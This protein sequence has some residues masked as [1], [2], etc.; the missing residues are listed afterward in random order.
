MVGVAHQRS[1]GKI[2]FSFFVFRRPWLIILTCVFCFLHFGDFHCQKRSLFSMLDLTWENIAIIKSS[3]DVLIYCFLSCLYFVI[4]SFPILYKISTR[5]R[6]KMTL[7]LLKCNDLFSV[8]P[9]RNGE[10]LLQFLIVSDSFFKFVIKT[11][12]EKISM[13]NKLIVSSSFFFFWVKRD[14]TKAGK[15]RCGQAV[16]SWQSYC[17]FYT[18]LST[19]IREVK[20]FWGDFLFFRFSE[21]LGGDL[22]AGHL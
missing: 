8:L 12:S 7:S 14:E 5:C 11:T 17:D 13:E 18:F 9:L 15:C 4:I 10:L 3:D 1:G 21:S 2:R 22:A 16:M 20:I 19:R 6:C